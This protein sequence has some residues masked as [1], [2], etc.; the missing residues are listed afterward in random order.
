MK[1]VAIIMGS[2]SDLPV[3]EKA[4]R[5]NENCYIVRRILSQAQ[6]I[7]IGICGALRENDYV[8]KVFCVLIFSVRQNGKG[9]RLLAKISVGA[10]KI[11]GKTIV[12]L[13]SR[14]NGDKTLCHSIH[15]LF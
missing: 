4:I 2:A 9:K 7:Q 12:F 3:V 15:T 1:K 10:Q 6:F 8:I 13:F 11:M 14:G 5:I